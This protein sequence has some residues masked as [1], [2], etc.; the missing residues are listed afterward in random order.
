MPPVVST[1]ITERAYR[2]MREVEDAHWWFDGMEAI[3]R[4]LLDATAGPGALPGRRVLDAGCGTGRNL[5]FLARYG[6]VTGLD[7]S[8]VALDCCRGRGA[9]RLVRGS[10]NALPFASGS[11]DLV[12]SFDVL[13]S[14]GVQDSQAL[15][16]SARVLRP[17]GHLLVRVAAY[18]RLRGGRHDEEW[19]IH[20]RYERT[21]LC[22]KLAAAGFEIRR[23]SYANTWLFPVAWFKRQ[24]ERLV[25][26]RTEESDLQMGAGQT[27]G[28]RVLGRL[29]ASEARWVTGPGVGLP[30]GLSLYAVGRKQG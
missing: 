26:P 20:H 1:P 10:A 9:Q 16:E 15:P 5:G 28:G 7:F 3:T 18:D 17:G 13:T 4:R 25:P 29:L 27:L 12:T 30:F 6:E 19:N 24:L 21:E 8:A 22:V 23:A 2:I 11:F 14:G